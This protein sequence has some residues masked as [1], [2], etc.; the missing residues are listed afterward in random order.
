MSERMPGAKLFVLHDVTK[1]FG[2][3]VAIQGVVFEVERGEIVGL[4]GD[5]G[6]GKSTLVKVMNGFYSPDRGVMRFD[7]RPVRFNS[8][9]DARSVGIET[10]YQD[11]ALIPALSIWRNFF[12]GRELKKGRAPFMHLAKAEMRNITMVNLREMG[13]TRL[14]SPDEPVDILSGGERQALAI[15]RARHFGGSLLVLDEPTSALSVKETEKVSEAVRIARDGGLGVVIIDHNIGHVHRI[16]DRIVIME[17][18][19]VLSTVRRDEVTAQRV[20]DMVAGRHA[21]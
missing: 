15:A 5:N 8:P 9:R 19:R 1:S 6:A 21:L 4:V 3:L 7:G 11:L 10:V 13:L 20:A 17:S 14:R 16:C 2:N 18:G 12:L